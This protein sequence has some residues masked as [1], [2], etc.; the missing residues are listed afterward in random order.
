MQV[1]IGF[2]VVAVIALV[3]TVVSRRFA[4]PARQFVPPPSTFGVP[5]QMSL[6]DISPQ[7]RPWVLVLF[8]SQT[9]E[10][11]LRARSLA[12]TIRSEG[13]EIKFI[14]SSEQPGLFEK[15]SIE[16]VPLFVLCDESGL[17]CGHMFG[18]SSELFEMIAGV[19]RSGHT[20]AGLLADLKHP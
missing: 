12:Q 2:A 8:T 17:V 19:A 10:G 3:T 16:G 13:L 20:N 15:Y 14:D 18:S 6:E 9:C 4:P 7:F 1:L 5:A 11:C